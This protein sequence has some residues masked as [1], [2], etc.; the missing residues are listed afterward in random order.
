ML[1]EE[2]KRLY[3]AYYHTNTQ[4]YMRLLE[5]YLAGKKYS[6]NIKVFFVHVFFMCYR[7]MYQWVLIFFLVS[8]GA[9]AIKDSVFLIYSVP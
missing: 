6:I 8:V 4:Y 7:K 2:E 1:T 9:F 5:R 3:Q